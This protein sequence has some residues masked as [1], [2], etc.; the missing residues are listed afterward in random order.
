MDETGDKILLGRNVCTVLSPG[1]FLPNSQFS[2]R[3][4]IVEK[5]AEKLLVVHVR[6]QRAGR[7]V[8][9][10]GQARAVGGGWGEG[11]ERP[12]SFLAAMGMSR[13]LSLALFCSL[14][15]PDARVDPSLS[16]RTSCV[17]FTRPPTPKNRCA[18]I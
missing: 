2:L 14:R 13:F 6:I 12:V 1:R 17:G 8:R 4:A 16:L 7:V 11:L 18:L 15:M 5:V 3:F 9:G 10:R